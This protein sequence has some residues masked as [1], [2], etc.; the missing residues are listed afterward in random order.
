VFWKKLQK[1]VKLLEGIEDKARGEKTT[2][3]VLIVQQGHVGAI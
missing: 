3:G 1:M 2:A